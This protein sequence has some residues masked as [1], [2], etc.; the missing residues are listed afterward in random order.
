MPIAVDKT[1]RTV[2]TFSSP[3]GLALPTNICLTFSVHPGIFKNWSNSRTRRLQQDH[4]LLP[5][6]KTGAP[7][8]CTHF[9]SREALGLYVTPQPFRRHVAFSGITASGS[10]ESGS[11]TTGFAGVLVGRSG[12]FVS[13]GS[14]AGAVSVGGAAGSSVAFTGSAAGVSSTVEC[15]PVV[16]GGMARNS[17][18][19]RTRG[20]QHFQPR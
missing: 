2:S 15:L 1:Y 20:L 6:W 13:T 14:G 4:P 10:S 8:W 17:S 12:S 5:S 18:K 11:S 9:S 16:Q 7:G 3:A 19:V